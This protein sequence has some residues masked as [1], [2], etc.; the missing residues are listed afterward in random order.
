LIKTCG[1]AAVN[2]RLLVKAAGRV[3]KRYD[4]K[5][6]KERDKGEK[7]P[8]RGGGAKLQ[9]TGMTMVNPLELCRKSRGG[10]AIVGNGVKTADNFPLDSSQIGGTTP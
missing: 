9:M 3:E 4:Y 6:G 10:R 8:R 1:C 2:R 7:E 5:K